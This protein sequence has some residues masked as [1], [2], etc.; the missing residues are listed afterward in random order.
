[1]LDEPQ[2]NLPPDKLPPT[3]KNQLQIPVN[4]T[5]LLPDITNP[6]NSNSINP[7]YKEQAIATN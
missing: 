2:F 4:N 7:I 5:L 6:T 3:N 1:M